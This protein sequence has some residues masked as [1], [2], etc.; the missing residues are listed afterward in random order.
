MSKKRKSESNGLD[1]IERTMYTAF[2]SAANSLS[3]LYTQAQNQQ[4]LAFQAGE[5][6]ALEKLYQSIL[7]HQEEGVRMTGADVLVYLQNELDY[8]GEEASVSPARQLQHH[9][10]LNPHMHFPT[11]SSQMHNVASG[12]L[13]SSQA[14][15]AMNQDQAKN[16]IFSNALSSPIRRSLQ[17]GGY[18]SNR[19]NGSGDSENVGSHGSQSSQNEMNNGDSTMDMHEEGGPN[20]Y[21]Q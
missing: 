7:R 1:E 18:Y 11:P 15:R 12:Q 9:P 14:Q 6:H 3:L 4:K 21:Y 5:R 20:G 17:Q 10:N 19:R 8:G 13:V 2:S 16:S